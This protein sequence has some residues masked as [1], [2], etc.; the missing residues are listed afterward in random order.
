MLWNQLGYVDINQTPRGSKVVPRGVDS[1]QTL[2]ASGDIAAQIRREL[3]SS[4][5]ARSEQEAPQEAPLFPFRI[6]LENSTP[7]LDTFYR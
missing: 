3:P 1:N 2:T 5:R 7:N 4:Q 6:A